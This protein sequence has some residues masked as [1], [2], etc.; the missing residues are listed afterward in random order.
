[1]I[2]TSFFDSKEDLLSIAQEIKD[3]NSLYGSSFPSSVLKYN[4]KYISDLI[5]VKFVFR[6]IE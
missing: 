2:S 1:V 3:Y 4:F 5:R 6:D